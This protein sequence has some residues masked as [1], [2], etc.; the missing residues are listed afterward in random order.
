V[1]DCADH[2]L[3]SIEQSGLG[4]GRRR[5]DRFSRTVDRIAALGRGERHTVALE[6]PVHHRRGPSDRRRSGGGG[7][8]QT[9]E[10][11]RDGENR[12]AAADEISRMTPHGLLPTIPVLISRGNPLIGSCAALRFLQ[13]RGHDLAWR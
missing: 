6:R 1:P 7:D 2:R 3:A 5:D 4:S 12:A 8:F 13:N 9:N 11:G 10:E